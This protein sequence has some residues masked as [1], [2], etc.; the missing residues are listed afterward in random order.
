[1]NNSECLLLFGL[2]TLPFASI[3][4]TQLSNTFVLFHW[5][6]QRNIKTAKIKKFSQ[7]QRDAKNY[8]LRL[9][10]FHKNDIKSGAFLQAAREIYKQNEWM[11]RR[12]KRT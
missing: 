1:M 12:I 8:A 9:N 7:Q 4:V 3:Y 5:N 6:F 2:I 11:K 10:N